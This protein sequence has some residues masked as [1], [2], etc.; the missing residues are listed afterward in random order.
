MEEK[1]VQKFV[2]ST[3]SCNLAVE[4]NNPTEMK[5]QPKLDIEKIGTNP[6]LNTLVIPVTKIISSN[7]LIENAEGVV[8]NKTLYMEKQQKVELYYHECAGDNIAKLSD[9][10]QRLLLHVLYTLDRNKDY[11]WLNKQHYMNRNEIKSATTVSNAINE[12]IRYQY[13]LKTACIGWFWVN[14][15]RF[16]PGSRLAKYPEKKV[17]AD[18]EWDQTKGE[19]YEDRSKRNKSVNLAKK[20]QMEEHEERVTNLYKNDV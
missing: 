17:I 2:E 10:A 9:K 3:E 11:Y 5:K 19:R 20:S 15:Y 14:P 4:M 6:F 1:D 12:L 13:L 18:K 16:F 8:T 7:D